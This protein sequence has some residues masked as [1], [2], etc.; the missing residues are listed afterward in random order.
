M[1]DLPITP[2]H[3][4]AATHLDAQQPEAS[5]SHAR[6]G[7]APSTSQAHSAAD[8]KDEL[9]KRVG[10]ALEDLQS[11][12]AQGKSDQLVRY[13]E[14]VG[15]F[16]GYS[17]QN[18]LLILLQRPEATHVAGFQRWKSLGRHVMKGERGIAILAP[19]T[20][21]KTQREDPAT[22]IDAEENPLDSEPVR[23]N[24]ANIRFRVVHV[25]D[26]SQTDG[27]PLPELDTIRGDPG[28]YTLRLTEA[29]K[30]H[31]IRLSYGALAGGT[32]GTS[33]GGAIE[34]AHGLS[35]AEQFAVLVH[36]F[37]HELLHRTERRSQTNKTIR[38]TEAEAVAYVVSRAIGL[39]TSSRSSDYIQ[40]YDGDVKIL[41]ESLHH[42][43]RA[44]HV[45]LEA[46][47]KPQS[48]ET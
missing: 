34:I 15:R 9:V 39:Q 32:L 31:G 48:G 22:P 2:N 1:Q 20:S 41:A 27:E 21:R 36:E 4:S 23:K 18:T 30:R 14:F 28:E 38:E 16:H 40:L 12:L 6:F 47:D 3:E 26:V 44:A 46:I 5:L 8:K 45:I 24:P 33:S 10:N 43:Q 25:F 19:I 29:I 42:I 11:A 7:E 35:D 37:A 17:L 13:L